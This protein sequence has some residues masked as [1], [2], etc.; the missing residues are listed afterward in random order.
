MPDVHIQAFTAV[1]I[2]YFEDCKDTYEGSACP[3]EGC[4]IGIPAGGGQRY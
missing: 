2:D 4:R 1:E 3:A